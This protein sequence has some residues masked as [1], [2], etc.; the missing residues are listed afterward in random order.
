MIADTDPRP[1]LAPLLVEQARC[2]GVTVASHAVGGA[3]QILCPELPRKIGY[4]RAFDVDAREP[5]VAAA[6]VDRARRA[7]IRPLL[8]VTPASIAEDTAAALGALGLAPLWRVVALRLDLRALPLP[9]EGSG[10]RVRDARPDE[11][12]AFGALAVRAYG[13]P[14]PGFP[15][16]DQGAE[17]R[18]WAALCR[19][20][21]ARCFLA[22]IDG[23]P[24]AVGLFVRAGAV[25]LVDGAATLAE[26]RGRGCQGALVARRFRE[27]R[28]AGA[29]IAITRTVPG[30][31]SQRN[32]ERAGMR[33][34]ETVE[35]WG[36]P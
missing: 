33:V 24:A 10:V 13:P 35:V 7:G 11:A 6:L 15:A 8:E 34:Y 17:E 26:H 4:N 1:R 32:L 5:G 36:T 14:L 9:E 22:E 30:W 19:L 12:P 20:G 29:S 21:Q 2:A 31:A 3:V 28:A 25:A 27:A 23:A 16:A 18:F